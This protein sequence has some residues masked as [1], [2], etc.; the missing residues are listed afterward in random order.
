MG[1][2]VSNVLERPAH[3]LVDEGG[4]QDLVHGPFRDALVADLRVAAIEHPDDDDLGQLLASLRSR[5]SDFAARWDAA[6]PKRHQSIAKVIKHPRIGT[7]VLDSDVL[8]VPGSELHI[9]TYSA[10]P[11][12]DDAGR[13][14]LQSTPVASP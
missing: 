14:N 1:D 10:E 2:H 9:I 12:T 6:R 5:S 13:L 7:L 4:P 3:L 11:G 8:H